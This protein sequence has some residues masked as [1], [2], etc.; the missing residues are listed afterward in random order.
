[1]T[2]VFNLLGSHVITF[3]SDCARQVR[4][5]CE[6]PTVDANQEA[7]MLS[8]PC[9]PPNQG[10]SFRWVVAADKD[11]QCRLRMLASQAPDYSQISET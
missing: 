7:Q 8:E 5:R 2:H 11:G 4:P 1:M 10:L 9:A 3:L 6:I